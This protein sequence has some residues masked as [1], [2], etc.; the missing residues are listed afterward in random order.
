MK[1][2]SNNKNNSYKRKNKKRAKGKIGTKRV[3]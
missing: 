2:I 3:V 1:F